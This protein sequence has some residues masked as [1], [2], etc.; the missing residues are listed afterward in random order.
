MCSGGHEVL[1]HQVS[2]VDDVCRCIA[3]RFSEGVIE[4]CGCIENECRSSDLLLLVEVEYRIGIVY[5]R[6]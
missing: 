5:E 6:H 1:V 3:W 2:D 4:R